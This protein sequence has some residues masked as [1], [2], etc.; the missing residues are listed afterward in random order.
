MATSVEIQNA[1]L[2]LWAI[3]INAEVEEELSP[4]AQFTKFAVHVLAWKGGDGNWNRR[5][6][7]CFG[8]AYPRYT[9]RK[10]LPIR[11]TQDHNTNLWR[12]TYH[13]HCGSSIDGSIIP[14]YNNI[15]VFIKP[16]Q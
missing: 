4:K 1:Y 3:D 11:M 5:W 8:E 10:S 6:K 7:E 9:S 14:I 12:R 2:R 16:R 13:R 15:G